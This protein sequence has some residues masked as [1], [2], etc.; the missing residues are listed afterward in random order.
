[1][2]DFVK[3]F[4]FL[5]QGLQELKQY[6]TARKWF[7]FPLLIDVLLF[8]SFIGYGIGNIY[9]W[10]SSALSF[11]PTGSW[12]FDIVY[13][14]LYLVAWLAFVAIG[15]YLV[16]ILSAVIAA[17]FNALVA[18][19]LLEKYGLIKL[20]RYDFKG[21]LRLTL[22]MFKISLIKAIVFALIAIL[23]LI[24]AFI[25]GLNL[26]AGFLAFLIIAFDCFDYSFEVMG[27][28][29]GERIEFFRNHL[30]T[31]AGMAVSLML[32][33]IIPGLTLLVLPLGVVGAAALFRDLKR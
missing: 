23:V 27:M 3:G 33:L 31:F 28:G 32:T 14:P 10:V 16:F 21:K 13:Y 26:L 8:I 19:E 6:K 24:M 11:I 17:P 30:I 29:F 18:E 15:L 25:P 4:F 9:Q 7:Y 2:K 20:D 5:F 12:W 22:R 1:M